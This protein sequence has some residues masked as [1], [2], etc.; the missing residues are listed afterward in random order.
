MKYDYRFKKFHI[1]PQEFPEAYKIL[2]K[3][4]KMW[5]NFAKYGNPTPE[6]DTSLGLKWTPVKK[7]S[8]DEEFKLDYLEIGNDRIEMQINPD[9]ER[10]QFWRDIYRK[11]NG[12]FMKAKL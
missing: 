9:E 6:T 1:D 12:N 10:A 11:W 8:V 4:C 2:G 5:T 7:H 3:M